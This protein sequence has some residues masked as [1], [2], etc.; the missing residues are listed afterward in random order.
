MTLELNPVGVA[1]NIACTYCYEHPMRDAGNFGNKGYDLEAMKRGLA[2]EGKDFTLH[3]GEPLLM[4]I[5]DLEEIWR[6]GLARYGKNGIQTNGALITDEHIRLFRAYKV[7]VG[8]S[9]DGPDALND[10]R[11]A[12]SLERTRKITARSQAALERCLAE[13]I[14]TSLII[15][16]HRMNANPDVLARLQAWIKDLATLGLRWARLHVMEVDH[17]L[18]QSNLNLPDAETIQA[19]IQMEAFERELHGAIQF[20]VFTDLRK[21]LL[22]KDNDVTCIWA[23]CDPLTTKAVSG[24]D[25]TGERTNCGRTNKDGIGWRKADRP[26]YERYA[27]LYHTPQE[28]GG[29]QGCR[30]FFACKGTCP[31]TAIDGDWRN[32]SAQCGIWMALF[33]HVEQQ[34]VLEGRVPLSLA[35]QRDEVERRMVEAW[36]DGRQMYIFQ[37]LADVRDNPRD[38][39]H[40]DAPHGDHWDSA[41]IVEPPE[42]ADAPHGDAHGDHTDAGAISCEGPSEGWTEHADIPH[43]DYTDPHHPYG[44]VAHADGQRSYGMVPVVVRKPR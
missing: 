11:W 38:V 7:Q 20:D 29:C 15:T 1:C 18:V 31:G 40:G 21:L 5:E 28:Y 9:M 39:P 30:F 14:E 26:G 13:G 10:A 4:P 16:L 37:A 35:D 44:D 22:G 19:M 36:S 33:E 43:G 41:V 24:I 8:I 25:G 17:A 12:G 42:H 2:A 6:W 32:R 3:G 27:A 34:L 23:A